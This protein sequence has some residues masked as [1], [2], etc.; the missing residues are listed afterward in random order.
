MSLLIYKNRN[1]TFLI[2]RL[3][4]SVKNINDTAVETQ[5]ILIPSLTSKLYKHSYIYLA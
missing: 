3:V 2:Y 4:F 5:T 1:E